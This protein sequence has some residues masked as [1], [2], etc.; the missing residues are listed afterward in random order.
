[1]KRVLAAAVMMGLSLGL[2]GCGDKAS[3]EDKRTIEGPGGTTEI[4]EE[5]S[6]KTT[7]DNPPPATAE[8]AAK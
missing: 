4:K 2:T 8:P 7:G 6:V 3:V 5:K 1:M